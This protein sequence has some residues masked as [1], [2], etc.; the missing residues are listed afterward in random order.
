MRRCGFVVSDGEGLEKCYANGVSEGLDCG[1]S[2]VSISYDPIG[3]RGN[4]RSQIGVGDTLS[5]W[6]PSSFDSGDG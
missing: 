1:N 3:R 6:D 5:L 4:P 2:V